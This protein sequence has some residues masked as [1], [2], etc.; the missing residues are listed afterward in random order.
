MIFVRPSEIRFAAPCPGGRKSCVRPIL[1]GVPTRRR[2]ASS[3]PSSSHTC[4]AGA[5]AGLLSLSVE[6]LI[7]EVY[8]SLSIPRV[9]KHHPLSSAI[10]FF[11]VFFNTTL[12]PAPALCI[13]LPHLGKIWCAPCP[14]GRKS[15]VRGQKHVREN[16]LVHESVS[17]EHGRSGKSFA[18][19]A[20]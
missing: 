8:L 15:C 18:S 7:S 3:S 12:S 20:N 13:S 16:H 14:R 10:P 11:L 19:L 5:Q 17:H 6:P 2:P 4:R 9:F 1:Q